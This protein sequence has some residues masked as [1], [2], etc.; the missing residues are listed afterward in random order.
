[1]H[2]KIEEERKRFNPLSI[3]IRSWVPNL[4]SSEENVRAIVRWLALYSGALLSSGGYCLV[5][6][7]VLSCLSC[8]G[9]L[10]A[11]CVLW[12]GPPSIERVRK[13]NP[14]HESGITTV[15]SRA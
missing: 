7:V 15:E 3:K 1:M 10:S 11:A 4:R 14:R 2:F 5:S 13:L 6:S 9:N 12:E 8:H